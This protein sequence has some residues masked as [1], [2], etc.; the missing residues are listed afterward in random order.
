LPFHI[1][2]VDGVKLAIR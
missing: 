2:D 1:I